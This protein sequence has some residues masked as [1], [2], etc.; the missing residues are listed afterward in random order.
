MQIIIINSNYFKRMH[1]N[2]FWLSHRLNKVLEFLGC[3]YV[4][5]FSSWHNEVISAFKFSCSCPWLRT[6]FYLG[7]CLPFFLFWKSAIIRINQR[8]AKALFSSDGRIKKFYKRI[9]STIS[10]KR[11]WGADNTNHFALSNGRKSCLMGW[12]PFTTSCI[13]MRF[14][15]IFTFFFLRR[16]AA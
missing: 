13:K 11:K 14:H 6:S 10:D 16:L 8:I 15:R 5:P 7:N 4:T 2:G 9:F 1:S 3:H 12:R